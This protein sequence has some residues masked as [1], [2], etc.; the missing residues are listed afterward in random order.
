MIK[1]LNILRLVETVFY[2]DILH[3]FLMYFI[4]KRGRDLKLMLLV[5]EHFFC[6]MA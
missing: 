5:S 1:N 4:C 3:T 2:L 6:V